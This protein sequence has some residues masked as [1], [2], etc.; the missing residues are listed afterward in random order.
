MTQRKSRLVP[1][2][3]DDRLFLSIV[4]RK[5]R[6]VL[7]SAYA[8][9]IPMVVFFSLPRSG[10]KRT[11]TAS[12]WKKVDD[13]K[14]V[15]YWG[16]WAINLGVLGAATVI[17]GILILRK[18]VLSVRKDLR[19]GFKEE[20]DYTIQRK[21]HFPLTGQ[22]FVW[23]DDPDNLDH[24]VSEENYYNLQEGDTLCVYR[25]KHS[26]LVFERNG[27]FDII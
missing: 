4:F 5:R 22:Y 13:G 14:V 18:R 17:P 20:V 19:S 9:L 26:K 24:E 7:L 27:R 3:A 25:G 2:D 21:Q 15:P 16:M 6:N 1:L 11:Y 12:S 10:P 8:L 23:I